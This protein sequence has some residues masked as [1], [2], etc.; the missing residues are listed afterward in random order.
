MS[1]TNEN[2]GLI[3]KSHKTAK[4]AGDG[5]LSDTMVRSLSAPSRGNKIT[6]EA[7]Q[8]AVRGFGVRITAAGA[9]SFIVNYTVAGRERRLTIGAYPAWSVA[10]ARDE[11]KRLRREID[12]GV[13]PLGAREAERD[14]ATIGDL[15]DRYLA[16]HAVK[17]RT[18]ADDESMIRRIIRPE[19]GSRKVASIT[20]ADVDRLHRRVSEARGPYG[21]NRL[22]ALL[23]KMFSLAIRWE[24][25]TDNPAKGVERNPEERRYRYLTGDELRRLTEALAAHANQAA[26]NAVRLLLLT[27]ARRGEVL[28]AAWDQ[29]DLEAGIWTKPSSH[30]KQKREHRVPLSAPARQLLAEIKAAAEHRANEKRR[31]PSPYVFPARAPGDGPMTEIK[32]SWA[33]LCAAADLR[34]V[35]IHD[36]RHTY[37]SVLASAGLS[38]P[39]I[40]ALL[41]H[42]QPLTTARYAHLFDDPLRAATERVGAIVTGKGDGG[43]EIVPIERGRGR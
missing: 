30:T 35:R 19:L 21:A 15:C 29:F 31:E 13:D 27:G 22:L 23:S 39:V 38:L 18:A 36:L 16:E 2:K 40:G 41:G 37:A 34:G 3:E 17:K 9:K 12:R 43:G 10:A 32:K 20:F 33:A 7:G 25:R 8:D 26:A 4:S 28:G 11:A 6:Y 1:D 5:R 14:A 24:M 42:T